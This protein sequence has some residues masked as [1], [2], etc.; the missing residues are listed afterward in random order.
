M[1]AM[2]APPTATRRVYTQGLTADLRHDG[3]SRVSSMKQRAARLEAI[4]RFVA[5][6]L[7]G[8]GPRKK[9]Q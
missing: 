9:V 5:G 4:R 8:P 6:K 3:G 2:K 7:G 1:H